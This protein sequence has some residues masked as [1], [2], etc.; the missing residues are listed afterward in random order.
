MRAASRSEL[1]AVASRDRGR[2]EAHARE[3]AIP[4]AIAG[5]ERLVEDPAIDAIYVPLPNSEHVPWTLRA[6]AA[7][8]HVLCEKPL[9][10]SCEDIDRIVAASTAT[11]VCVEEGFMYRHE[12]LTSRVVELLNAGAVGH[13]RAIA[14]G[15]TFMLDRGPN[16]RLDPVLGGGALWDIGSY[17]VTY[18]Q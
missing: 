11:R 17:P 14:S 1:V 5:Y 12:P 6:I 4:R 8:K 10:L 7:R 3:Y 18:A 15:F 13:I 9:A 16:I 2:A